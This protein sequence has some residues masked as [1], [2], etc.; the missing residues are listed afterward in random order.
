MYISDTHVLRTTSKAPNWL[1][2][3]RCASA[4]TTSAG[5]GVSRAAATGGDDATADCRMRPVGA[6]PDRPSMC[7]SALSARSSH[8]HASGLAAAA[9]GGADAG[10]WRTT[11]IISSSSSSSSSAS[12][13]STWHGR[14]AATGASRAKS[15]STESVEHVGDER[16]EAGEGGGG[17]HAGPTA[18]RGRD[19]TAPSP[20]VAGRWSVGCGGA[21]G[22]IGTDPV[23]GRSIRRDDGEGGDATAS[24]WLSDDETDDADDQPEGGGMGL[25]RE[26]DVPQGG[27]NAGPHGVTSGEE[28][29]SQGGK[30]KKLRGEEAERRQKKRCASRRK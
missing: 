8:V 26:V 11:A 29:I 10:D 27:L 16:N 4:T 20:G 14:D 9:A 13:W 2:T 18:G 5:E 28:D 24:R 3:S 30:E 6:A 17:D 12:L 21:N 23:G 25:H 15:I 19:N 22:G 1:A 7:A